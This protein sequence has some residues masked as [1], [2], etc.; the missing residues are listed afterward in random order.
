M[1]KGFPS[2]FSAIS[3]RSAAGT[4]GAS[5]SEPVMS[6]ISPDESGWSAR[7]TW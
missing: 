4:A 5:S 7:R 1:K 6:L 2:A 3:P